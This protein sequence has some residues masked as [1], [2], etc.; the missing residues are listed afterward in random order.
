MVE[1]GWGSDV[2]GIPEEEVWE[3]RITRHGFPYGWYAIIIYTVG[4]HIEEVTTEFRSEPF[5]VDIMI[6]IFLYSLM[7]GFILW[8]YRLY[9]LKSG[10]TSPIKPQK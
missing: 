9:A 8:L 3:V 7:V 2:V 5:I 10:N 1:G 6:Y 4:G